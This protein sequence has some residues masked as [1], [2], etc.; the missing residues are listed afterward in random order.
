ML[1]WKL[2]TLATVVSSTSYIPRIVL[3]DCIFPSSLI[4]IIT[5]HKIY[6]ACIQSLL[7]LIFQSL[8]KTI[9]G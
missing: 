6:F 5:L 8:V 7:S 3:E 1:V 2:V 9:F 4:L